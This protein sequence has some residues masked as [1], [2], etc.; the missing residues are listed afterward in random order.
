MHPALLICGTTTVSPLTMANG[1][2]T[3]A[4]DGV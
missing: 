3:I 4:A 1:Y 2:A